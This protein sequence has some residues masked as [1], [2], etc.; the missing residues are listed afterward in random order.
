MSSLL[1]ADIKDINACP[2]RPRKS[3]IDEN[4]VVLRWYWHIVQFMPNNY[5]KCFGYKTCRSEHK[6][7]TSKGHRSGVVEQ[8]QRDLLKR[9]ITDTESRVYGYDKLNF[10][11]PLQWRGSSCHKVVRSIKK[12]SLKSY[13]V[14]LKQFIRSAQSCE[15]IILW[16]L[17]H[18]IAPAYT[19]ARVFDQKQT[20]IMPQIPY[21]PDLALADF[22]L[23]PY[24][25]SIFLLL[26]R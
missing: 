13:E 2:D 4:I 24:E 17:R 6:K 12:T 10:F 23:F 26:S 14:F 15:R 25:G 22:F 19:C 7:T 20:I 21:S 8:Q 5:Y 11:L 9:V 18:D 1:L 16:I 3:T